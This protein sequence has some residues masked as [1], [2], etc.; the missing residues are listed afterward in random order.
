MTVGWLVGWLEFRQYLA[1]TLSVKNVTEMTYFAS[2][3]T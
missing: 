1:K 2:S 3:W